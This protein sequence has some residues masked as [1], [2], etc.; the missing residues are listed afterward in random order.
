MADPR[1]C[2][3]VL[4]LA[5]CSTSIHL[6][7]TWSTWSSTSIQPATATKVLTVDCGDA[8]TS[9]ATK[10][11]TGATGGELELRLVDP[12]GVERHHQVVQGGTCET[13]Q[14]WPARLGRWTL[15]VESKDFTGSCRVELAANDT[16]IEVRVDLAVE[17]PIGAPR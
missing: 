15:H 8:A 13:T 5:A 2:V 1:L 11:R 14:A 6:Q 7:S 12:D 3:L 16:P 4:P 9:V 17:A 10:L